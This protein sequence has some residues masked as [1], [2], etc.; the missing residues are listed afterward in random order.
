MLKLVES[1]GEEKMLIQVGEL[2]RDAYKMLAQV[3]NSKPMTVSVLRLELT[4]HK[5][6]ENNLTKRTMRINAGEMPAN[7][8]L[9]NGG[10]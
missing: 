5:V 4:A 2:K 1:T 9:T 8:P 10:T 3:I 7:L 6:L